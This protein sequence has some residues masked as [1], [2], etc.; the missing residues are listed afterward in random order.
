MHTLNYFV[1]HT[2]Q[3]Y[4]EF[5]E[6]IKSDQPVGMDLIKA[7]SATFAVSFNHTLEHLINEKESDICRLCKF[8]PTKTSQSPTIKNQILRRLFITTFKYMGMEVSGSMVKILYDVGDVSKHGTITRKFREIS[9]YS[10]VEE[11]LL[12][13]L[14]QSI[15]PNFYSIHK[16]IQVKCDNGK[17]Y[18]LEKVI[19]ICMG[20][21]STL[22]YDL[23]ILDSVPDIWSECRSFDLTPAEADRTFCIS[24]N[25]VE[26]PQYGDKGSP[27]MLKQVYDSNVPQSI[28]FPKKDEPFNINITVP[29]EVV[30]TPYLKKPR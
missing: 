4:Q 20:I 12:L 25:I 5:Q 22:L 17:I 2:Y 15:K 21:L 8:Y 29:V 19:N 10:Q 24:R 30:A 23:Q 26:V 1:T 16:G 27:A 18:N 11:C 3:N 9:S 14:N 13:V 28:R 6:I 7:K